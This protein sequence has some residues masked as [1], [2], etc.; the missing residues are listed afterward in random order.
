MEAAKICKKENL[1]NKDIEDHYYSLQYNDIYDMLD[2]FKD[3]VKKMRLTTTSTIPPK[4]M[5]KKGGS[6]IL[7]KIYLEGKSC[8]SF[9]QAQIK[10]FGLNPESY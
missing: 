1:S 2:I 9:T 4:V 3:I 5:I 10:N 8:A 7:K 6:G